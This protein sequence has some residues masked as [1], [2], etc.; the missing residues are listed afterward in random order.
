MMCVSPP[1]LTDAQLLACLDG[2]AAREVEAHLQQCPHC[3]ERMNSLANFQSRL[4]GQLYRLMCPSARELGEYHLGTLPDARGAE[5]HRHL[6]ECPHCSQ[7][8]AQLETYLTN[9]AP[10]V[11]FSLRE[12]VRVLVA[13]L[14][15]GDARGQRPTP[16][17]M[18]P[19]GA[20]VRGEQE[21]VQIFQAEGIQI[22]IETQPD[23]RTSG[24]HV[25]L[26]LIT[27]TDLSGWKADLW[28]DGQLVVTTSIDD[29]GNLYLAGLSSGQY[30]LVLTGADIEIRLSSVQV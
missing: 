16:L 30:E 13:Q 10:D 27:G 9:L 7:E 15:G 22:V 26:G 6:A 8:L 25:L 2:Q 4:T 23:P 19:V 14:V 18:M 5:V 20:G 3:R 17:V 1:E 11:E 28:Q 24:K 12:K 21:A 29:L